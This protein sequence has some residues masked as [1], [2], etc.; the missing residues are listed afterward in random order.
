MSFPLA[1]CSV[2]L[3]SPSEEACCEVEMER[4]WRWGSVS[5]SPWEKILTG[6]HYSSGTE[7]WA[8]PWG[9]GETLCMCLRWIRFLG[10]II[11]EET[12]PQAAPPTYNRPRSLSSSPPPHWCL[13]CCSS[14][15]CF[16][17]RLSF[18]SYFHF[19]TCSSPLV[20][21]LSATSHGPH[22]RV[23][24]LTSEY[25]WLHSS[26]LI[27]HFITTN[28][29]FLISQCVCLKFVNRLY[30]QKHFGLYLNYLKRKYQTQIVLWADLRR[31]CCYAGRIND[32]CVRCKYKMGWSEVATLLIGVV[33]A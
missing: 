8:R 11:D 12:P 31:C 27:E 7:G 16:T 23:D 13:T 9:G 5:Q 19:S 3:G 4:R 20:L 10:F 22:I 21:E 15:Q 26:L 29:C 2:T 25:L 33:W 24:K 28:I 32:Y 30:G 17:M 6:N 18:S 14:Q 1:G